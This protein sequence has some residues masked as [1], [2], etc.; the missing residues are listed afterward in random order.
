MR[1]KSSVWAVMERGPP[2]PTPGH[3]L[4]CVR[5]GWSTVCASECVFMMSIKESCSWRLFV[6]G[7]M[8]SGSVSKSV[9]G[10]K[11]EIE[12]QSMSGRLKSPE[13]QISLSGGISER[14]SCNC[15]R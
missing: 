11:G 15:R 5:V 14:E 7:I 10:S 8:G 1:N 9:G 4:V 3:A 13:I 2:S 12:V 6:W